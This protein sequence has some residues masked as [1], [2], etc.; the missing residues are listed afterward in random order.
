MRYS[1]GCSVRQGED[2][3]RWFVIGYIGGIPVFILFDIVAWNYGKCRR[4]VDAVRIVVETI[5]RSR[6]I[7]RYQ[8]VLPLN[9]LVVDGGDFYKLNP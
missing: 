1:V 5:G 7:Q 6:E 2:A 3:G 4:V 9:V 8:F